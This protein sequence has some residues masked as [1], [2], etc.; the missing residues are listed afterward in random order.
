MQIGQWPLIAICLFLLMGPTLT[1][2]TPS[3]IHCTMNAKAYRG[4]SD[5]MGWHGP[6]P[7][8]L[9]TTP[10]GYKWDKPD[11]KKPFDVFIP[12]TQTDL[13]ALQPTFVAEYIF[14]Q[15]DTDTPHVRLIPF[16]KD[17]SGYE[18][19]ARVIQRTS[20]PLAIH[21][22]WE[23]APKEFYTVALN[24]KSF[25]AGIGRIHVGKRFGGVGVAA[26]TADCR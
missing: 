19:N 3:S 26:I 18:R 5:D 23:G 6:H 14:S 4:Y 21:F 10:Q 24:L 13:P 17:H 22:V 7:D 12:T 2:Q 11:P 16:N 25:K 15:L 9:K 20:D 1:A 8:L